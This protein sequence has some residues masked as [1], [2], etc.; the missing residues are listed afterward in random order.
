M[1]PFLKNVI[2]FYFHINYSYYDR[3]RWCNYMSLSIKINT[4]F[5]DNIEDT[6]LAMVTDI[7]FF[8]QTHPTCLSNVLS[9]VVRICP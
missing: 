9:N 8:Q 4:L 6:K 2:S 1:F 3:H 5:V 7:G